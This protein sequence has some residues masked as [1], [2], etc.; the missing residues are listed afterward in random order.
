MSGL[1]L[2]ILADSRQAQREV[3]DLGEALDKVGDSLNDVVKDSDK[4]TQRMERD[5]RDMAREVK[6][7]TKGAYDDVKRNSRDAF[8]SVSENVEGFKDEAIQNFS[9]V[10]SSFDGDIS[11]MADGVQG[12]TGGLASSLTP[13]IG[14][15]VAILGAAAG[16]FLNAWV[17]AAEESKQRVDEMYQDMIASGQAFLSEDFIS[18]ALGDIIGDDGK[19][20]KAIDDAK[21][22]GLETSTV[23]RATAGDQAALNELVTKVGSLREAEIDAI[24]KSNEPLDIQATKIDAINA[25]Y[26]EILETYTGITS[27]TQ[28]AIDQVNLYRDA[29]GKAASADQQRYEALGRAL[30][31]IPSQKVVK[32]ELDTTEA[33]N[34]IAK[35]QGIRLQAYVDAL[36]A[37]TGKKIS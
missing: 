13:G 29:T 15:P 7:E 18:K 31:G 5:F 20:Q 30:A 34:K 6:R 26:G 4:G 37:R 17:T 16:A 35:L 24:K 9:E 11:S 12:L 14:I 19:R 22:L 1:T 27:E 21:R 33:E 2:D 10:A 23:L 32:L 25:R 28:K 8:D 3:G 36:E